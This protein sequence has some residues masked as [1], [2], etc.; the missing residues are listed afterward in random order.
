MAQRLPLRFDQLCQVLTTLEAGAYIWP[1]SEQA[2]SLLTSRPQ[3][4]VGDYA[5]DFLLPALGGGE[6]RLSALHGQRIWLSLNRQSTCAICN[7]RHAEVIA[8]QDQLVP[9]GVQTVSIWGSTLDD[10]ARGIGKQR[11]PYAVLADP[12]DT[13]YT[14]YGLSFSLSGT[15]DPRNL[16]TMLRGF[17]MMGAA[18]LKSDGELFR[19]PAEFLIGRDGRIERVRYA[20]YGADFLAVE[21]VLAWARRP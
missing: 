17:R 20:T 8:V 16:G 19:M 9:L 21:E 18:A 2:P 4:Q 15:L 12:D 14:R 1:T 6:V 13:T 3:L 5:P 7:P 11:P 10:L